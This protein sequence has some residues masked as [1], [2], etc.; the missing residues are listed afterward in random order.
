M[1]NAAANVGRQTNEAKHL[2]I[3]LRL[4]GVIEKEV[5]INPVV[6]VEKPITARSGIFGW[7]NPGYVDRIRWDTLRRRHARM[8]P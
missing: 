5:P 1:K 2:R 6:D 7:H 8:W 3:R 4:V